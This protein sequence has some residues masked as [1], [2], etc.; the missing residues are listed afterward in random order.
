MTRRSRNDRITRN[1]KECEIATYKTRAEI[2]AQNPVREG[3]DEL[4][5]SAKV[6]AIVGISTTTLS[7]WNTE[8]PPRIPFVR[9]SKGNYRWRKSDLEAYLQRQQVDRRKG[10]RRSGSSEFAIER[11]AADR[12]DIDRGSG[13]LRD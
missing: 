10:D 7:R 4:L 2:I 8:S 6:C 1:K 5:T 11:R 9:L 13:K 12:R 3:D